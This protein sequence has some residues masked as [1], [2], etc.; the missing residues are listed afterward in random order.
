MDNLLLAK[1]I[2][3]IVFVISLMLL[4]AWALKKSGL[5]GVALGKPSRRLQVVETL[6]VHHKRRLVLVRCD[7]K[8]YLL[9]LGHDSETVVAT[10][11]EAPQEDLEQVVK[12]ARDPRNVKI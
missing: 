5:G 11:I 2:A 4:L 6:P 12:F 7:E 8:E 10:G 9:M 1:F 3:G